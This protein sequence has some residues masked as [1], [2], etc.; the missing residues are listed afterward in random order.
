MYSPAPAAPDFTAPVALLSDFPTPRWVRSVF[1]VGG[2]PEIAVASFGQQRER[3]LLPRSTAGSIGNSFICFGIRSSLGSFGIALRRAARNFP[4]LRSANVPARGS[5]PGQA[6]A[7]AANRGR[8]RNQL[9]FLR[10]YSVRAAPPG[11][12]GR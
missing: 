1:V 8:F 10:K 5:G 2:C 6:F 11:H 7:P 9:D 3:L 12:S 4:W